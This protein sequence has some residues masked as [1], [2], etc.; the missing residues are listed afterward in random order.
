MK[1]YY[2]CIIA[3]FG[4]A[5]A[6][7]AIAAGRNGASVLVLEKNTCPG[8]TH[9]AGGVCGYYGQEPLGIMLE[10]DEKCRAV[11]AQDKWGESLCEIKKH[12]IEQECAKIKVDICYEAVITACRLENRQIQEIFWQDSAGEHSA[13]AHCFIDATGDALLCGLAGVPLSCGR[14]S[15]HLFQP[16]TYSMLSMARNAI[17][18]RNFDAGRID[19]YC[20][21]EFSRTL[22]EGSQVHLKEEY[23]HDRDLIAPADLPGIREGKRLLIPRP[24]TLEEFFRNQDQCEEPVYYAFSNLDT[25]ANDM[26]LENDLFCE[27][28]I[29]CSMWGFN[30]GIPVPRRVLSAAGAGVSNLLVAGRNIAVDHNLGHAL[31]MNALMA[32][33]GEAAGTIA[34]FSS[35]LKVLPDE[36]PYR[37]FAHLLPLNPHVVKDNCLIR[38]TDEE[39]I[40]GELDSDCP[41]MAMWSARA[42]V[43][44]ETLTCWMTEAPEKSELRCHSAMVLAMKRNPAGLEELCRMVRERDSYV[45]VHS[46]KYNHQRGYSALFCLR[47]LDDC[48]TFPLL[49]DVLLADDPDSIYQYHTHA[50]AGLVRLG[51]K[52]A[53]LRHEAALV[54]RKRAEDPDW[55]L[56][57]RLKGTKATLKRM[58]PVFRVYIARTLKC[59]GEGNRIADVMDRMELDSFEKFLKEKIV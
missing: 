45:P 23:S 4:T 59:W 2:D 34:A 39:H 22:L 16:Y 24:Y 33:L 11:S 21:D 8:G 44:S 42:N 20:E 3:G 30:M 1:N 12:L 31:R 36:V 54:L 27:W 53:D 18:V 58:D 52:Y 55:K 51:G 43:P 48:R 6:V 15:D 28:M 25:H 13:S 14:A 7:A 41:G 37:K 32:G 46:R 17:Q 10:L 9:T 26:A 40:R 56:E 50:I 49:R 57:S 5:G 47:L 35:S 29:G 19:P 38:C